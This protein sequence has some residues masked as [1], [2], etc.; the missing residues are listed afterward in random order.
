MG[1][2]K[3]IMIIED[4]PLNMKLTAELLRIGGFDLIKAVDGKSAFE[5]LR[6]TIPD[7]IVLDLQLPDIDGFEVMKKIRSDEKTKT[8]KVVAVTASVMKEDEEQVAEAGFDGY[9]AKPINTR[10]FVKQ[11]KAILG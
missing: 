1:A 4:N 6:Q 10:E 3:T 8:I 11:I 2:K 7:L 9:I 5:I